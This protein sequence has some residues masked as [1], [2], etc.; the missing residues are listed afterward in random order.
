VCNGHFISSVCAKISVLLLLRYLKLKFGTYDE[1]QQ[2]VE[3]LK[4]LREGLTVKN[5]SKDDSES[6]LPCYIDDT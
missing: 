5:F 4:A 3:G 1:A 2:A 6:R